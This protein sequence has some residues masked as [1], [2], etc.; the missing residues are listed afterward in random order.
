MK[1]IYHGCEGAP[2]VSTHYDV[3]FVIGVPTEV[4]DEFA[5]AKLSNHPHFE[6]LNA[7]VQGEVVVEE[8][9]DLVALYEKKFGKKPHHKMKPETIQEK[10]DAD[11][12]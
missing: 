5:I 3:E 4:E 7:T 10:L 12:D 9:E 6:A 11:N 2:Q 8:K 1:I